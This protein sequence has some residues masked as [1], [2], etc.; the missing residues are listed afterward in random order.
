MT[1]PCN[2]KLAKRREKENNK[3]GQS[4]GRHDMRHHLQS[5]REQ[6]RVPDL[7]QEEINTT[8]PEP[9]ARPWS[10][11]RPSHGLINSFSLS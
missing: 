3:R 6:K 1:I 11:N 10:R 8:A 7:V 9:K 2:A 5:D 4:H